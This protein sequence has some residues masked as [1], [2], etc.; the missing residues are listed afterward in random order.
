MSDTDNIE[1]D[2]CGCCDTGTPADPDV[3]RNAPG[4]S[5]LHYRAA[6]HPEF[7]RRRLAALPR[8]T[9]GTDGARPLAGL[10]ARTPD[11]PAIALLDACLLY[12]SDA[13]DE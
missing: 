8:A 6:T 4:L 3:V 1:L 13:A 10:T 11:D 7:L 12:T 2:A 9:A 5:A